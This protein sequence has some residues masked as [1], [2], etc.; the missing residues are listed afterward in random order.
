MVPSLASS[1]RR[2]TARS[3]PSVEALTSSAGAV[4]SSVV[5]LSSSGSTSTGSGTS[6]GGLVLS[7][8]DSSVIV[9]V[10]RVELRFILSSTPSHGATAVI[11]AI[12]TRLRAAKTT[13][14][15]GATGLGAGETALVGG[16]RG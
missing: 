9:L 15:G 7:E 14:H 5:A 3:S 10:E 8:V 1:I 13:A 12:P 6:T 16:S 4:A 11:G 2:G